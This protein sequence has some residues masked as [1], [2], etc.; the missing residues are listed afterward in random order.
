MGGLV[1]GL[2]SSHL[3]ILLKIFSFP[4]S[5]PHFI[6]ISAFLITTYWMSSSSSSASPLIKCHPDPT[7]V[8][9]LL[10]SSCYISSEVGL[11]SGNRMSELDLTNCPESGLRNSELGISMLSTDNLAKVLGTKVQRFSLSL[12]PP[13]FFFFLLFTFSLVFFCLDF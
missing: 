11:T 5:H 3:M 10:M 2:T 13:H 8:S 6:L 12:T 1:R 7:C 9:F 4:Y